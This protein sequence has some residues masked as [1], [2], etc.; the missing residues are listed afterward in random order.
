MKRELFVTL[1]GANVGNFLGFG[2]SSSVAVFLL[3]SVYVLVTHT[4][5]ME[6]WWRQTLYGAWG[7]SPP[8]VCRIIIQ[9]FG[10]ERGGGRLPS[11]SPHPKTE[12]KKQIFLDTIISNI[13]WLK[14]QPKSATKN[15]WWPVLFIWRDS[16]QWARASSFTRFLDHTQRRTSSLGEWSARHRDLYLTTHNTHNRQTSMLTVRFEPAISASERPQTY[17]LDRATTRTGINTLEYKKNMGI[18]DTNM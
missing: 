17:A 3:G 14:L 13:T 10:T 15:G 16:P 11:Y 4:R 1:V 7:A 18:L 5:R 9:N 8:A 2:T 12:L 6:I